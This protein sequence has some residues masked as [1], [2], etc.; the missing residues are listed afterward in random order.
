MINVIF[1]SVD[2]VYDFRIEDSYSH[3]AIADKIQQMIN[4]SSP[5]CLG[6]DLHYHIDSLIEDLLNRLGYYEAVALIRTIDKE[7][8]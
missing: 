7:Y 6:D 1:I 3:R 4:Q 8:S 5:G 2:N